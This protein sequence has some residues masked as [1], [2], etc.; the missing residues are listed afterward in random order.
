MLVP[1]DR[2]V[3]KVESLSFTVGS[4]N[5][6]ATLCETEENKEKGFG[7]EEEALLGMCND[8]KH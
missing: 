8:D 7:M 4:L 1:V 2:F 3:M 6:L 5:L